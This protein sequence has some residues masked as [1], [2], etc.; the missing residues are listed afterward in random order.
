[1][2]KLFIIAPL[3][4]VATTVPFITNTK[5]AHAAET[6]TADAPAWIYAPS[7]GLFSP[8][9][10]VGTTATGE[11]DVPSGRSNNVGWYQYG[12]KPGEQGT[13]VLDAHVFAAFK[14][15]SLMKPGQDIYIVMQSGKLLHYVTTRAETYAINAL[16]PYTLFAP[17]NKPQLNLIT[18]AGQFV[19]S[20]AT[21]DHRLIVSAVLI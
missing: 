21:Y 17:S 13:A 9:Q 18:C 19:A 15:L 14:N 16:S 6:V 2:K 8:I 7:I 1:M 12:V 20:R 5:T 11:M 10:G 4:L 3:L